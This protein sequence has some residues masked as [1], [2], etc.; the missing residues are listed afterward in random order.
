MMISCASRRPL[1]HAPASRM[2]PG[3]RPRFARRRGVAAVELAVVLPF[4][5]FLFVIAVD[6]GRIFYYSLTVE[7]CAR[8]G[9]LYG[10][11]PLAAS[12]SPYKSISE[13]ALADA[14]NLSPQPTVSSRNGADPAGNSYVEVTVSWQFSTITNYPGVPSVTT[15]SRTVRMRVAPTTPQ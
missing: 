13:A 6:Y 14:S 12:Q 1:S 5:A 11:D 10:S 8:N 9:A 3:A 7:N 15:L 4:L 2:P